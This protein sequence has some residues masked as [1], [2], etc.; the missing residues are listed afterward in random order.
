MSYSNDSSQ[1]LQHFALG[2]AVEELLELARGQLLGGRSAD[3]AG[4][5]GGFE[6]KIAGCRERPVSKVGRMHDS[7]QSVQ[8]TPQALAE[9]DQSY[10]GRA[11]RGKSGKRVLPVSSKLEMRLIDSMAAV[12]AQTALRSAAHC[13]LRVHCSRGGGYAQMG[14]VSCV[15]GERVLQWVKVCQTCMG[16]QN[17][18]LL[19]VMLGEQ[20]GEKPC[21]RLS[22]PVSRPLSSDR[23]LGTAGPR[24]YPS[25]RYQES[26]AP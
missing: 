3:A 16:L 12:Y 7:H 20:L 26:R 4:I 22:K 10:I 25:P 19:T 14:K 24:D 9:A 6:G 15:R 21:A 11:K 5:V 1:A 2:P 18:S 17:E 8:K 13:R 23:Q